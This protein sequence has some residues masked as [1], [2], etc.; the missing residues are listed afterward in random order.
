LRVGQR[1]RDLGQVVAGVFVEALV[2]GGDHRARQPAA[3]AAA[4][5]VAGAGR[6]GIEQA[7]GAEAADGE[8][9]HLRLDAEFARRQAQRRGEPDAAVDPRLAQLGQ[10]GF[11]EREGMRERRVGQ[12]ELQLGAVGR[13]VRLPLAVQLA[14]RDAEDELAVRVVLAAALQAE[15]QPRD[16]QRIAVRIGHAQEARRAVDLPDTFLDAGM[17]R[18]LAVRRLQRVVL[19]QSEHE[20]VARHAQQRRHAELGLPRPDPQRL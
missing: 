8:A 19:E 2:L 9:V 6:L 10:V 4:G 7:L 5:L 14:R 12:L 16:T 18:Q 1:G 3:E 20:R 13:D 17:Q 11:E 15:L